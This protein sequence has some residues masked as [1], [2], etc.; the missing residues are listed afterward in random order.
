MITVLFD[1]EIPAGPHTATYRDLYSLNLRQRILPGE[2]PYVLV[3]E[4]VGG[5]VGEFTGEEHA[6]D[7]FERCLGG[8]IIEVVEVAP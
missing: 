6:R 5:R 2:R 1:V 8:R 7:F 4:T 3:N